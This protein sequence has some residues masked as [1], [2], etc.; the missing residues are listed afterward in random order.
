M[1]VKLIQFLVVR[2]EIC[3]LFQ[4]KGMDVLRVREVSQRKQRARG[5]VCSTHQTE[6][7]APM[8]TRSFCEKMVS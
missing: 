1:R 5:T 8:S 4:T 6:N 3:L 7:S 2:K